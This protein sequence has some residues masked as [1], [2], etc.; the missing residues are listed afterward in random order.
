MLAYVP[1]R[2]ELYRAIRPHLRWTLQCLIG[3]ADRAGRCFPS[4]RKLAEV[5]GLGKSTVSRH[6]AALVRAGL[7]HRTRKPG[8]VY[9]YAV[10]SRFLPAG[11]KLSHA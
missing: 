10:D 4:I 6:L 9:V 8:G 11:A 3:F 1:V 2:F 5:T 7:I